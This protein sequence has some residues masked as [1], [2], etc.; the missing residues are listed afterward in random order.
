MIYLFFPKKNKTVAFKK[1]EKKNNRISLFFFFFFGRIFSTLLSFI[2]EKFFLFYKL[3]QG[4]KSNMKLVLT[5][6]LDWIGLDWIGLNVVVVF[7]NVDSLAVC[8]L[9]WEM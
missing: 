7:C 1:K 2:C 8:Y 4:K 5:C 9:I 3:S 6:G